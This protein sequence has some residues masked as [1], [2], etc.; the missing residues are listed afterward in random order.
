MIRGY[1]CITQLETRQYLIYQD[2]VCRLL[3]TLRVD[4][5]VS[6]AKLY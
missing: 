5:F 2:S 3:S 4:K 6:G 1:L